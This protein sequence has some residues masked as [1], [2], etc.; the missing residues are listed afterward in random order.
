MYNGVRSDRIDTRHF[1]NH[2]FLTFNAIVI[3]ML[4]IIAPE[5][6]TIYV[7]IKSKINTDH[8]AAR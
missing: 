6:I 5:F 8:H 4:L 1:K 3:H 7:L 2:D